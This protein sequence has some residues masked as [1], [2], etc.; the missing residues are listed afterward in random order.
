MKKILTVLFA[1][2]LISGCATKQQNE[3]LIKVYTRDATS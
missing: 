2:L 3:G 1:V